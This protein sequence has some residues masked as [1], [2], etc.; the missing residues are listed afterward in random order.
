EMFAN[1]GNN[2]LLHYSKDG[3]LTWRTS[4][5]QRGAK[6]EYLRPCVRV[7]NT[8]EKLLTGYQDLF[9]S[10]DGGISWVPLNV[11]GSGTICAIAVAPSD[12]KVMY[13]AFAGPSW[14]DNVAGKLFRSQDRGY[15][16]TDISKGLK[17]AAWAGIS[18]LAV[19]PADP[20][21]V[22]VGFRG[23]SKTKAMRYFAGNSSEWVDFS[24]GMPADADVNALLFDSMDGKS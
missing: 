6:A 8:G 9:L 23:G 19:N 7:G 4:S 12:E 1:D 21:E 22:V 20:L 24:M 2:N 16:W 11:P 10:E 18:A 15:S 14:S 17:G 3:G 5:P 13:C